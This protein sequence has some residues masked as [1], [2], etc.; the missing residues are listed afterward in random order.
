MK[1]DEVYLRH[2]DMTAVWEI[3]QRDLPPLR[4]EI[5]IILKGLET[6]SP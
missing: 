3:T 5:Q 2:I 6:S 1:G 4:G